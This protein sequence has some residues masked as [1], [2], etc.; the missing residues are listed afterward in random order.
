MAQRGR[1][2]VAERRV[3]AVDDALE[4]VTGDLGRRYIEGKDLEGQVGEGEVLPALPLASNGNMLGDE[5]AAVRGE[6]LEDYLFKGEL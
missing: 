4:V 1:L 6:A 2:G 3:A 5:Q